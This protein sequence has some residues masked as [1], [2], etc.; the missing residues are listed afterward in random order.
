MSNSSKLLL[1]IREV[2]LLLQS[3]GNAS[4]S[5]PGIF[6]L[7][8][9]QS[10]DRRLF[11]EVADETSTAPFRTII[12]AEDV[13]SSVNGVPSSQDPI[14]FLISLLLPKE[15]SGETP[16]PTKFEVLNDTLRIQA[17]QRLP[18]G[19][20][21]KCWTTTIERDTHSTSILSSMLQ[22]GLQVK[23]LET[24]KQSVERNK[25]Q[26]MD[27]AQELQ[28][29]WEEEKSELLNNFLLLY[30]KKQELGTQAQEQAQEKIQQLEDTLEQK[31]EELRI[32]KRS[33]LPDYED[34]LPQDQDQVMYDPETVDR[35]AKRKRAVPSRRRNETTGA[36]EYFDSNVVLEDLE[37]ANAAKKKPPPRT[38]KS[39]PK[40]AAKP[41][42]Q[43][44]S[45]S[46][47][48]DDDDDDATFMKNDRIKIQAQLAAMLEDE[49]G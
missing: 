7:S 15:S 13:K 27:T 14:D 42:P 2:A 48:D 1:G 12:T 43:A 47:T 10:S 4:T 11:L 22:L 9:E 25:D 17:S 44:E 35:L 6:T 41:E 24:E 20:V 29:R 8:E 28:G 33:A 3:A 40:R 39:K 5:I 19:L 37:N 38:N 23:D 21:K 26:W 46:E 16:L 30:K 31:E 32:A 45:G 34:Q 49:G 18:S 36:L